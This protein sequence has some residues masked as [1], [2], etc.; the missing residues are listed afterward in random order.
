[1]KLTIICIAFIISLGSLP[2]LAQDGNS[3]GQSG[4]NIKQTGQASMTFL[5][6]GV[7]PKAAAMGEAYT[8]LSRGVESVFYN[9]AGLTEMDSKY[10]AFVSST[11]WFADIKYLAAA[12]GYNAGDLGAFAFSFITVDY[13]KIKGTALVP[14]SGGGFDYVLTGDVPNVGAYSF[15]LTYVKAIS[16]KFSIGGTVKYVGQQ[17]GQLT[18]GTGTHDNNASKLVFDLGVKYIPGIESLRLGMSIRNFS[19]F[20]QYQNFQSP[21]PLVFSVGL[22]MNIM[23][24][25]DKTISTNHSLILSSEFVHP[26]DYTERVNTGIEYTFMKTV[27]LRAGYESNQDIFGWSGGL[28]FEHSIDGTALEIDYSYST[29]QY[30]NG[31]NRFSLS[32]NF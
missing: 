25:I 14:G 11:Q 16:T 17:L 13:G 19:T 4:A 20:V 28:G 6:V 3:L 10:Q 12:I 29:T 32:V 5:L 9:P 8:A 7:S 18:D 27:S 1:M 30:F 23:D 2:I 21:L 24:V 26:N 22:G 15:G 31:V